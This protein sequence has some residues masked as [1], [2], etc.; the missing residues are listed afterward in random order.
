M[1]S[2]GLTKFDH[3]SVEAKIGYQFKD[4]ALL[5]EACTHSS[6]RQIDPY[7]KDNERLEFLGDSVLDIVVAERLYRNGCDLDPG[8]M[9]LFKARVVSNSACARYTKFLG[10]HLHLKRSGGTPIS[11]GMLANQFEAVLGALWLEEAESTISSLLFGRC[12]PI[13]AELLDIDD[14]KT[15]L[16]RYLVALGKQP[17][18]GYSISLSDGGVTFTATVRGRSGN[19]SFSGRDSSI[20]EAERSAAKALLDWDRTSIRVPTRR[21]SLRQRLISWASSIEE[22]EEL[23][24]DASEGK[25]ATNSND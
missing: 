16:H 25:H 15:T 14:H 4:H 2:T 17:V 19:T 18:W 1:F 3:A 9:T 11:S 8:N 6:Y 21:P 7:C 13:V 23:A 5:E 12:Y 20:K 10:L 22:A 24:A